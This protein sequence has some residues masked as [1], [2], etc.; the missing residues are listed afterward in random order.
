M[1]NR[2][3]ELKSTLKSL[4]ISYWQIGEVI[5][6]HEN[7]IIRWLREEP[8]PADHKTLILEAIEKL[9]KSVVNAE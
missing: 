1:C 2:N 6:K 7:T 5:G 4:D 3:M 8:L 9:K